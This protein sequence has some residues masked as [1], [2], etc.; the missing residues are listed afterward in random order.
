M[1]PK[2]TSTFDVFGTLIS[3]RVADPARRYVALAGGGS[4]AEE[5]SR[6]RIEAEHVLAQEKGAD[7]Y[8]LEDIYVRLG[9]SAPTARD[10]IEMELG[11]CFPVTEAGRLLASARKK[12]DP[13]LFVSD[14]YLPADF[15]RQLL[16]KHGLW[17]AGDRLYVSHEQGTPKHGGLFQKIC[18]DLSLAPGQIKHT[19]DHLRSDVL[20]PRRLGIGTVHFRATEPSRYENAWMRRAEEGMPV[21]DAIRAARLQF[22]VSLDAR[23]QIFWE[24]ACNVA[25]PLFIAYV[26]WLEQQARE[27]GLERLYFISRDGLIFKKVYDHLFPAGESSPQSHY[28]YGSRQAWSCVRAAFLLEEDIE[29]LLQA[30]PSLSLR[31]FYG[32]CGWPTPPGIR[33]AWTQAPP[34]EDDPL[35]PAQMD[36]LRGFMRGGELRKKIVAQGQL[37]LKEAQGFLRQEGLGSGRYG[38]V[39]LGW[40]GNLQSFVERILPE[41]PPQAGFYLDL[42]RETDP[43]QRSLQKAFLPFG[44]FRGIRGSVATTLLEILA[45]APHG[46]VVGYEFPNKKWEAIFAGPA[47]FFGPEGPAQIHHE[48]I[49]KTA[50]ELKYQGV[51]KK[52]GVPPKGDAVMLGN[53]ENLLAHPSCREAE[54]YGQIHFISRQEG[55]GE[56]VF[57]PALSLPEAFAM[58]REGFWSREALWPQACIRRS[59]GGARLILWAR[60]VLTVCK[61]KARFLFEALRA[62]P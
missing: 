40:H 7:L 24:T 44:R 11:L 45:A 57:A 8:S 38:L 47:S 17:Q 12:G 4:A 22:P 54:V 39:D 35:R 10:E 46:T 43:R 61:E 29:A 16:E 25:G 30:H 55:G 34:Q 58:V 26:V 13:V 48:A 23:G 18:Q 42:R 49:L 37:R 33:L 28:L 53:L 15:I 59:R 6:R 31:Q 32:R 3:R 14:M 56:T 2:K 60:F 9:S 41:N 62:R 19:G 36:Q 50:E 20:V 1:S 21:A 51:L 27:L 5:W 52:M